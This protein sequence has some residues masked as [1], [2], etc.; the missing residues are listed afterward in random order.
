M[1]GIKVSSAF[2]FTSSAPA[3]L[4]LTL[5]KAE[6]KETNPNLIPDHYLTVCQDD[7]KIYLYS[8][9]NEVDETTGKFRVFEGGSGGGTA[10]GG[11]ADTADTATSASSVPWSGI[12]DL[13]DD[14]VYDSAYVH[15]DAN[16]TVAEKAKLAELHNYDD[17]GVNALINTKQDKLT[18]GD[19]I[20]ISATNEISVTNATETEVDA[21]IKSVFGGS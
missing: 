9:D 12:T 10:T 5:T 18:A 6:M 17:S 1:A 4:R 20:A 19:G 3:D 11:H 14:I 16:F 7:G 21:M 15:S 2:Q 13:P 8:K